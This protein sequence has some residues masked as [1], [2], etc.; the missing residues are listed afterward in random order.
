MNQ[1][2]WTG[3]LDKRI[4][5]DVNYGPKI[6]WI[7]HK[8]HEYPNNC[9]VWSY[10]ISISLIITIIKH[11][12]YVIGKHAPKEPSEFS[13]F[14]ANALGRG[15]DHVDNLLNP[16]MTN[17]SWT[18]TVPVSVELS[19]KCWRAGSCYRWYCCLMRVSM[20]LANVKAENYT[21][22]LN[23][24]RFKFPDSLC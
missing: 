21:H 16:C 5:V 15:L 4:K 24:V 6:Q 2:S 13:I 22:Q 7:P 23:I 18:D 10:L 12:K 3:R 17:D 14:L 11:Q 8:N 20:L 9:L 1:F 19:D